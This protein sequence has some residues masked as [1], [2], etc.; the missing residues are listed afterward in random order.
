[1]KNMER[2]MEFFVWAVSLI[3]I[4]YLVDYS[5]GL[6]SRRSTISNLGGLLLLITVSFF[7]TFFI[8]NKIRRK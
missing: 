3:G 4:F 8:I 5:F 7:V 2:F 1:M 6:M